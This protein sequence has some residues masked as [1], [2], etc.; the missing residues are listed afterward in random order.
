MTLTAERLRVG[1]QHVVRD[2][3][4]GLLE[5][6]AA[7]AQMREWGL[8]KNAAEAALTKLADRVVSGGAARR[9]GAKSDADWLAGRQGTTV[10]KAK[11]R[12]RR[13][14]NLKK[15]EKTKK[16]FENGDLSEEQ[17]DAVAGA[18]AKHPEDEQRLLDMARRQSLSKLQ[19]EANRVRNRGEDAKARHERI[20]RDRHW[21]RWTD[22][23]GARCGV[24][25]MTPEQAA[26]IENHAQPY[27]DAAFNQG[28]RDGKR[29]PS[30]AYA[31]DGLVAMARAAGGDNSKA[32]FSTT[33]L[34]N[35]ESLRHGA[36]GD[37]EICE[38]P[39]VGPVSVEKA[40]E[41]LGPDGLKLAIVDGVDVRTVVHLGRHPTAAQRTAIYVRDRGRCVR[42]TCPRP[43]T[44]VD[45]TK[46]W[47]HTHQT[48][49]DDLAGLCDH[50]HDLKTH[51][52][53]TYRRGPNGWEWH[54][55]DGTTEHERPPPEDE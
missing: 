1:V 27:I 19:D 28:R 13:A 39:G 11:Q 33:L 2:L 45:H 3:D 26:V 18:A 10:G 14:A 8:I 15:A 31:A 55:P 22:R 46:D 16:A 32:T 5:V 49:F 40:L 4:P 48:S 17:A 34:A 41:L 35:I 38:I 6:A 37:G 47:S 44:Q 21:R 54:H 12:L 7:E 29:E 43:M 20:H 52:G 23:D 25:R 36:V 50:D 51:R 24:Y 9:D 42:P 53:H 30:E